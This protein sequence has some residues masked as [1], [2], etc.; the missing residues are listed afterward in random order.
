MI[1]SRNMTNEEK[2]VISTSIDDGNPF[3]PQVSLKEMI[4][5]FLAFGITVFFLFPVIFL[6]V[7]VFIG[8]FT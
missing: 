6:L 1:Y 7:C 2:T 5:V 4:R 3:K 8:D